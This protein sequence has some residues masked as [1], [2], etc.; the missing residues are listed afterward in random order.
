MSVC[1][2]S[3]LLGE[4]VLGGYTGSHLGEV[5]SPL[6]VTASAVLRRGSCAAVW[7]F[8]YARCSGGPSSRTGEPCTEAAGGVF[9]SG[10]LQPPLAHD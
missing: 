1:V 10:D 4:G 3:V 2:F 8:V 5:P 9:G 6:S 7:G